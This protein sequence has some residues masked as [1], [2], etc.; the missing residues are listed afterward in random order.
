[1]LLGGSARFDAPSGGS[2]KLRAFCD[3]HPES[4]CGISGGGD[5]ASC[6]LFIRKFGGAMAIVGGMG[7]ACERQIGGMAIGGGMGNACE[8]QRG[9]GM[10]IGGGV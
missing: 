1:M 10:A 9:G 7:N 8:R 4:P 3:G 2:G 5:A 6:G